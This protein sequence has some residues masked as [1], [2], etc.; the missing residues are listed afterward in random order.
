[1]IIYIYIINGCRLAFVETFCN[2][3]SHTFIAWPGNGFIGAIC[4][5]IA[6][7]YSFLNTSCILSIENLTI[8]AVVPQIIGHN[9]STGFR[10]K[11]LVI[12]MSGTGKVTIRVHICRKL[13]RFCLQIVYR[14]YCLGNFKCFSIR[15]F[16]TKIHSFFVQPV[17]QDI[18]AVFLI[19]LCLSLEEIISEISHIN[20][21]CV[22]KIVCISKILAHSLQ[23]IWRFT[24]EKRQI[25]FQI[26]ASAVFKLLQH[27]G[28]PQLFCRI[29]AL[30]H[31]FQRIH[32]KICFIN[33]TEQIHHIVCEDIFIPV[34]HQCICACRVKIVDGVALSGAGC[35]IAF[36][37]SILI[38]CK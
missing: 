17:M 26:I 27:I 10:G 29:F 5:R 35:C 2:Q 30:C 23:S 18:Q 13:E 16:C 38:K 20:L 9:R 12:Y 6:V 7:R 1:M 37:G 32:V 33:L 3:I 24:D 34:R 8:I 19:K 11:P 21:I 14:R 15:V 4:R 36:T 28:A 22:C 31:K 25:F